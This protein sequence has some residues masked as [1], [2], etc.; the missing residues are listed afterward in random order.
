MSTILT[1]VTATLA[2]LN[3]CLA[4]RTYQSQKGSETLFREMTGV[5]GQMEILQRG[6]NERELHLRQERARMAVYTLVQALRRQAYVLDGQWN[7]PM[8]SSK[9]DPLE[10]VRLYENEL[11]WIPQCK[12]REKCVEILQ[13]IGPLAP[14]LGQGARALQQSTLVNGCSDLE[15]GGQRNLYEDCLQAID[16]MT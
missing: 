5:L 9:S 11:L 16:E 12:W 10:P 14:Q 6:M 3:V 4:F 7:S 15:R 8:L 2:T 13:S 1:L